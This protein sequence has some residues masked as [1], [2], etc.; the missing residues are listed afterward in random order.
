[1]LVFSMHNFTIIGTLSE[2][3]VRDI[4]DLGNVVVF[5]IMENVIFDRPKNVIVVCG[6]TEV[7]F[8][9]LAAGGRIRTVKVTLADK[10][11]ATNR[12]LH[13]FN[14]EAIA[15]AT[16][17]FGLANLEIFPV[18]DEFLEQLRC[19]ETPCGNGPALH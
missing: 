9:G 2:S 1:M 7:F 6:R 13:A 16:E 8:C 4:G 17:Q 12:Y 3:I 18:S 19:A 14:R 10:V 11:N 5:N 15:H